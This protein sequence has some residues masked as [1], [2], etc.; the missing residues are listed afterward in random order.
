MAILKDLIV[1]G[2]SRFLNKIYAEELETSAFEAESAIIKKL[3]AD[4]ATVIGLLDV[5][6]QLHT[7]TWTN[8]NIATIDGCFY[9]TPTLSSN[10]G[11][12]SFTSNTAASLTGSYSAVTSLYIGDSSS[13]STVQWTKDSNI[14]LTGEVEVNGQWLPLGTLLGTLSANATTSSIGLTGLTDN[15]HN[16][17]SIITDIRNAVS[18]TA[19]DYRNL[20]ISLYQRK[21]GNDSKPLGIYMTAMGTNGKTFIDIYGGVNATTTAGSSGGFADPNL[22]IGNLS[23]LGAVEGTTPKGWGIYTTN[24]YFKGVIVSS[25]GKIGNFTINSAL[26]SNNHSAW[27]SNVS[28]IYINNDGISGGAGGK[29][30]L[31][32]DGSAKIGAMTLS[33]AGVLTVPAANVSGELTAATING[34]KISAGDIAAARIQ[35]N[36]IS[37][38]NAKVSDISALT[39]TLG[40]F[41]VDATAIHTKNVVIT[42]NADNSTALSSADFTRTINNVSR[43]GLRFAIGDKLGITGDGTI[44]ASDATISGNITATSLTLGSGV[45]I[46]YSSISNP[47]TIPTTVAELTDSGSY[48]TTSA[49][50]N[51]YATQTNLNSEINARKAVYGTSSTDAGTATKVV[52]CSNFALYTGAS[53]TVTFSKTNTS[54]APQMNV[55]S[56]GAKPIKSYTGAN[57]T[58]GEYKWAAGAS[59]TFTYDGTN[60]R[61]QDGGAL[62]AKIDAASSA[63]TASSQAGV[64][65]QQATNAT[66]AKTAAES[67]K[68]AA[69]SAKTAAQSAKTAAETASSQASSAKDTAVSAKNDAVS[70]KTDAE[71][72]KGQ[73]QTAASNASQSATN[74]ANSAT[75]AA[76]VMGGFTILWNY[77]AFDTSN[78]GRGYLCAFDPATG[79]KSDANGWVKW[80][81][82]KRT[83]TKQLINPSAISPNNIPIYIVCRLSSSTA[84]TGT[85][86]MVWYNS[87]WKSA[88]LSSPSTINSSWTWADSTDIILGKF[89]ETASGAALTEYEIYNPPYTSKQ[90]TTNVVTAQSASANA[91]NAAKTATSYITYVNATDGIKVHNASDMNNYLQLNSSAINF[92]RNNVETLKIE[93]SAIRVGK[94]GENE[95]NVYIADGAVQIRDNEDILAKFGSDGVQIGV[96]SNS[97]FRLFDKGI[98]GYNNNGANFFALDMYGSNSTVTVQEKYNSNR[99]WYNSQR[100]SNG[101]C[102]IT[103]P[104]N[105]KNNYSNKLYITHGRRY[106]GVG[107]IHYTTYTTYFTF[108]LGTAK[109]DEFF[110]GAVYDSRTHE[111]I[112][113]NYRVSFSYDGNNTLILHINAGVFEDNTEY[114]YFNLDYLLYQTITTAPAFTFGTR[115][116]AYTLGDFSTTFGLNNAASGA[117]SIAIGNGSIAASNYQTAIGKFNISDSDNTYSFIIGN[118]TSNSNSDRSNALT[119]DWNG[120]VQMYLDAINVE[121]DNSILTVIQSLGWEDDVID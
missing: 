7:N 71:T 10:S 26:Y 75:A 68:T 116:T 25:A 69:E 6:G 23:G 106:N 18:S 107:G 54:S 80:N 17:S 21:D 85:N 4:D 74:A 24:G 91:T 82:T 20:K 5:Q 81:G 110:I 11:K 8:S 52:T 95:Q 45:T 119:V 86:Y 51:T 39:A 63:S 89:V 33:A 117:E 84:T 97:K 70:A 121:L 57:L 1:H 73:A 64:A 31:W 96:D 99:Y 108:M 88:T 38:I 92:Y 83:I 42:S 36:L 102:I 79:T 111:L 15:R 113:Y 94:I 67:A 34:S 58:E 101:D 100:Q 47:P 44:Y 3:K 66:N 53:V 76:E 77:S 65:T 115:D 13:G 48:L 16:P 50:S 9:I 40:G 120:N 105:C 19:L 103:I 14:L 98:Y 46:G 61:M 27:N 29:W 32:N 43:A 87:G 78:N 12:I 37:A 72:A 90:I 22:R 114:Y 112:R 30:W 118:G 62:Q 55:N 41:Q 35:T 2:S 93:N 104:D 28:G 59:I 49:A 60:W 56:T 109:E